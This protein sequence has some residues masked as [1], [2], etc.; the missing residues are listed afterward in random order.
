MLSFAKTAI[1][2]LTFTLL[3]VDKAYAQVSLDTQW[4]M[5]V[6]SDISD[7]PDGVKFGDVNKDGLLDI[8]TAWEKD[9]VSTISLNPGSG[10]VK[11]QWPT[12]IVGTAKKAEDAMFM[13]IDN[14]GNVDVV[15]STEG[16][17]KEIIFH[18]APTLNE[19][20]N[21]SAWSNATLGPSKN[22]TQWMYAQPLQI[23]GKNGVDIVAGGKGD[24]SALGWFESPVNPRSNS[25]WIWH[26]LTTA[27]WIMSIEIN[28]MNN[29]GKQDIVYSDR[30]NGS[31]WLENPGTTGSLNQWPLHKI[32]D[33]NG[34]L[35]FLTIAD[36]DGDG[37]EDVITA[38]DEQIFLS[39]RM[40]LDGSNW[41]TTI[42][43]TPSLITMAKG[44][45]VTDVNGDGK[46]DLI[47]S[48]NNS[49][50]DHDLN[51]VIWASYN[52][53]PFSTD[54]TAHTLS[55]VMG[56]KADQVKLLDADRDGDL[57]VF[58]TEEKYGGLGIIWFENPFGGDGIS[59]NFNI[60]DINHDGK[61]NLID[62]SLLSNQ[63]LMSGSGLA[64]DLNGD[65]AVN[66]LD[67]SILSR[68]ID[69]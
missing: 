29:D 38:A 26:Q 31:R 57:D 33:A 19:I 61:I 36:L 9:G 30:S 53:T 24:D 21:P 68:E 12:V 43:N 5:H 2:T 67:L 11:E 23:D 64:A 14:D 45:A 69:F 58:T 66:L 35:G 47:L 63:F 37:L 1:L 15:S 39:K 13:D 50:G 59:N 40:S 34:R 46:K 20:N 65:G 41:E 60:A 8:A 56:I 4:P 54:W 51:I 52:N 3:T 10:L 55:G 32:A 49:H 22:V 25:G 17:S 62:Y 16:E 27:T 28:D 44:V 7:G 42:F 48:S 6:V 18:W